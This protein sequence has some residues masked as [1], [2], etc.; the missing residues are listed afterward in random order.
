MLFAHAFKYTAYL[1]MKWV[2][3]LHV[4]GKEL[5]PAEP[6]IIVANHSNSV[7]PLLINL[8]LLQKR[9]IFLT[10]SKLFECPRVLRWMLREMGCIPSI[11]PVV[12]ADNLFERSRHLEKNEVLGFFAQG[13]IQSNTDLFKTGTVML[14]L[15]TGYPIVPAYVKS[16]G[17]FRGKS[18][19]SFGNP[20]QVSQASINDMETINQMNE[21]IRT[22]VI[23]LSQ[24]FEEA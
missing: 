21:R 10:S 19:V 1:P 3:R 17:A 11:S 8:A 7:D 12:D 6:Y 4:R 23:Q 2:Y 14:A 13:K 5:L 16:E 18:F 9:I 15:R 24:Q 22:N 20:I